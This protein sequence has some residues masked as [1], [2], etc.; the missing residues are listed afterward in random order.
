MDTGQ[1]GDAHLGELRASARGWHGA[2]LAV[3]GFIGL[4]GVLQGQGDAALP[5]WLQILAGVLVLSA[6]ALACVATGLV[7]AVAWPVASG[8]TSTMPGGSGEE[9]RRGSS[10]LRLGIA[11][12]FLAVV[13]LAAATTTGWWPTAEQSPGSVEV[14]IGGR[15]LCGGL[16]AADPG[17]LAL[18]AGGQRLV[19]QLS[20]VS[21]LRVVDSCGG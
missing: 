13:A 5:R 2:Q 20:D 21:S 6:L 7:A 4:C 16:E 17:Q 11:L 18:V 12:T 8:P 9:L 10:R 14:T 3:L 19:L 15:V 1:P